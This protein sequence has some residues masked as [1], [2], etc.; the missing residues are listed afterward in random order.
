MLFT[1][2]ASRRLRMYILR[3]AFSRYGYN[4]IFD[5]DSI[6]SY[7][8]IEVGNDVFI[9]RGAT[10][11]ATKSR[12]IIG[13]KVMFGPNV[14]IMGGNHNTSVVGQFMFD[15]K[16]KRP[17]DDQ[18]VVIDDDVWIGAGAI[19]LKGVRLYRGCVVAAGAIVTKN[20]PPYTVVAGAPA[21]VRKVRFP[22]EVIIEHE[23]RLYSVNK[24]FTKEDIHRMLEGNF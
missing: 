5:P 1:R 11:Q 24:R 12:I 4:F 17:E 19:I 7:A 6:F 21:K 15:V 14:T 2:R 8:N 16:T 9:G 23:A 10:F 3:P 13:D 22:I 20:V 18:S